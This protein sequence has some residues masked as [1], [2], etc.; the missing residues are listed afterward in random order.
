MFEFTTLLILI[1]MATNPTGTI[2]VNG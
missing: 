2:K 1:A